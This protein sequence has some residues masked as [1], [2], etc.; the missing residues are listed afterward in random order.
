MDASI[1]DV[2]WIEPEPV[3]VP[4][5]LEKEVGGHPLIA[6]LLVRRGITDPA[7]ARA[8]LDP[9]FYT[10]TSGRELPDLS[11]GVARLRQALEREERIWI[12]GDFDVDGQ[13]ATALLYSALRDLGARVAYHVPTRQASHGLHRSGLGEILREGIDLLVTCD[14]G[15]AAHEQVAYCQ[16]HGVEVIITDHHDLPATLPLAQS[17]INPKR[18]PAVHPLHELTGVGCAYKLIEV[19]LTELGVPGQ[20]EQ[21][22]D[23]V[24]LGL[25]GDVAKMV[26]DVRYLVQ[27]GL[28]VLRNTDRVGLQELVRVAELDPAGLDEGHIG[29]GLAPRLNALGRLA[30]ASVGVELLVTG[31]RTRARMIASTV[32]G[33]NEERKLM[34]K[35]VMDAVEAQLAEERDYLEGKAL[36]LAHRGWPSGIIGIVAG[37][38]AER[39]ARPAIL[40]A[41]GEEGMARGSARSV[42]GC[43]IRA[44]IATQKELL[45][46]YGGHP[47]AA[48]F[49][50]A[51]EDIPTFVRRLERAISA[52]MDETAYK[53]ALPIDAYVG[54]NRISLGLAYEL[55]RLGPFGEG[56][57]PVRLA[58]RDVEVQSQTVIGR[59]QEHRRL[60]V[61]DK[62]GTVQ[63]VMQWHGATLPLPSGLFDLAFQL[64]VSDYQAQPAA[65]MVWIDA[66]VRPEQAAKTRPP[67]ASLTE[68]AV[69]DR[70][71]VYNPREVLRQVRMRHRDKL[72]IW[73]EATAE[74]PGVLDRQALQPGEALAIW[75]M[76]PGRETLA[77]ALRQVRPETVYL[78]AV[79]SAYGRLSPFLQQLGGLVKYALQHKEGCLAPARLAALLGHREGTVQAGLR[80]MESRGIIS[81]TAE[82]DA[83]HLAPGH[84]IATDRQADLERLLS[85]LLAET[86]AFRDYYRSADLEMLLP[87]LEVEPA[88]D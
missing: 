8:F 26:G 39:Y 86:R 57:P 77:A 45:P 70:R 2:I 43:D 27:R 66:R 88:T 78:F 30:D 75:T 68:L 67:L 29:Y 1:S 73:G 19:L 76:P 58:V 14:T 25:V 17:V 56:N 50:I 11:R 51:E 37:R 31:D 7:S 6:E 41:I 74:V 4:D 64:T 3:V 42:E 81:I 82:G 80:W 84:G 20:Q 34:V 53:P 61:R 62:A 5:A 12:W 60:L 18:L 79:P 85:G 38:L 47:M 63:E 55:N 28:E 10:P 72:I 49:A 16:A 65:Q 71:A 32:E 44:A 33:L 9:D 54:L 40:I 46:R 83:W 36:I 21:L 15:I 69:V 52:Q 22:L 35:Q 87:P 23:L 59:T 24:A 48:G 13:T